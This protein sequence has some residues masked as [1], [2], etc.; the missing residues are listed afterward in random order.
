MSTDT[1]G[2]VPTPGS[3]SLA[4]LS[5]QQPCR[6]HKCLPQTAPCSFISAYHSAS[7]YP[8][9]PAEMSLPD[10]LEWQKL[11]ERG[12]CSEG[13]GESR[14]LQGSSVSLG[15]DLLHGNTNTSSWERYMLKQHLLAGT[16]RH[17]AC[18]SSLQCMSLML[19][20]LTLQNISSGENHG[21]TY[22][23]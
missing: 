20:N 18:S 8:L 2:Q 22:T 12:R 7:S 21:P 15:T 4:L 19:K 3:C 10:L 16:E 23:S 5:F 1:S 13:E 14:G 17:Q 9:V 6:N 11:Q